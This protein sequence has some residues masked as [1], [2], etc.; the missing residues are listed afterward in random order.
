MNRISILLVALLALVVSACSGG[1]ASPSASGGDVI[2]SP[3]PE[4]TET[5]SPEPS[6]DP[7]GSDV[8][9]PSGFDINGDPELAARFPTTVGG[10][11]VQVI[12]FRGDTL[13]AGGDID[14]S[15][16]DFLDSTG[17]ELEDVSVAFG[18]TADGSLSMAAFRVLGVSEDKLEEE[19]LSASEE[20]GD[21]EDAER[22]SVGGKDVWKAADGTGQASGSV[23][24]YVKDDT[25]Y[26]LTG[27]DAQAAEILA[28]LP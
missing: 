17:A 11:A 22:T 26:F 3:S 21:I 10:E 14:P 15:F 19:F 12:S 25:V 20:A 1:G 6:D 7:S 24:L 16:Q 28:A 9:M 27:T 8:A 18:G 4:V 23:F 13:M 5:P 2:S